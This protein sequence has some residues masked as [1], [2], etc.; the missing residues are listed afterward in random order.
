MY[1]SWEAQAR[2]QREV[3]SPKSVLG[4]LGQKYDQYLDFAQQDAHEFPRI[5]LDAMGM[6]EQD[7][8]NVDPSSQET[9][10]NSRRPRCT[11]LP[12]TPAFTP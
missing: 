1:R 3:L 10:S 9:T 6:E 7:I 8:I 2:R 12:R 5:R 4:T 11:T